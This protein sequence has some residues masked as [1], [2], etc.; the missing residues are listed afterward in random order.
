MT[1]GASI[2]NDIL[3]SL[4]WLTAPKKILVPPAF[5]KENATGDFFVWNSFTVILK[6][7]KTNAAIS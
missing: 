2:K 5:L 6:L 3:D 7:L 4:V 1:C